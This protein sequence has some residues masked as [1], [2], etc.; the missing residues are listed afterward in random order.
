MEDENA[1]MGY[2]PGNVVLCCD[3]V[4]RMKL[5]M[6][7]DEFYMWAERITNASKICKVA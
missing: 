1:A 5:D 2:I 7:I 3:I 4:N 6:P